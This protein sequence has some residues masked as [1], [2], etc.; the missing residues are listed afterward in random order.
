MRKW[1]FKK[2]G[3]EGGSDLPRDCD[4][5]MTAIEIRE[6]LRTMEQDAAARGEAAYYKPEFLKALYPFIEKPSSGTAIPLLQVA[7]F[8]R[9]YFDK[10]SPGGEIYEMRRFLDRR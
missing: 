7:P 10:C 6:G 1:L 8:L 4:F 3:Q 5:I 9:S 2:L